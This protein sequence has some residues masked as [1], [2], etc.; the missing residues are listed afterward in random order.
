MLFSSYHKFTKGKD[1]TQYK[2]EELAC[3]L[4]K[5]VK[6]DD[7]N[8]SGLNMQEY[9][10]NKHE[11]KK[12]LINKQY[13]IPSNEDPTRISN[14]ETNK[15]IKTGKVECNISDAIDSEEKIV[16]QVNNF[17][18]IKKKKCDTQLSKQT[19]K[20]P[21]ECNEAELKT[22]KKKS[23][24]SINDNVND[25]DL[26]KKIKKSQMPTNENVDSIKC[27][28]SECNSNNNKETQKQEELVLSYKY[29]NLVDLLIEN[30]SAGKKYCTDS[31]SM[32][33][34]KIKEFI[35]TVKSQ[36]SIT[37]STEINQTNEELKSNKPLTLNPDDKN[38]VKDFEAQKSKVLESIK[39]RQEVSKYVNDKSMFIAEHGNILFFGSN[40]N[41]IK[42]YGDW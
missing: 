4:G 38:F 37:V 12:L 32:F 35:D 22:K 9:F 28:E 19:V 23:K 33:E 7:Q 39:K 42:G 15:N 17:T 14:D 5:G 1:L 18:P 2:K 31:N 41:E 3:I 40:M 30:S 36:H 10:K 16:E 20:P 24:E 29:Q 6:D 27:L 21:N 25:V 11:S 13:D 26:S 8:L 34:K